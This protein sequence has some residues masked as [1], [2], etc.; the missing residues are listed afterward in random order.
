MKPN[1]VL[2]ELLI[3]T[4]SISMWF[5][6]KQLVLMNVDISKLLRATGFAAST[7][8]YAKAYLMIVCNWSRFEIEEQRE[9]TEAS[10]EIE[11]HEYKKA[12]ELAIRKMEIDKQVL[13]A[14]VPLA[15]EMAAIEQKQH[16]ELTEHQKEQAARN[17]IE[18]ALTAPTVVEAPPTVVNEDVIRKHFPESMDVPSWK[19]ILKALQGGS[20][21]EEIVR[22]VLGCSDSLKAIGT[23]YLDFLQTRFM[24]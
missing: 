10:I 3:A 19:A 20:T 4:L 16:P 24:R 22:D 9:E 18:S 23:A 21:R 14:S 11:T 13:I 17:A 1:Q 2:P 6:P 8:F 15:N 7:A 12:A 5:T